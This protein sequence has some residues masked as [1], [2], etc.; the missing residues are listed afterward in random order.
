MGEPTDDD[1]STPGE[2]IIHEGMTHVVGRQIRRTNH[3]ASFGGVS[4]PGAHSSAV[5]DDEEAQFSLS[6]AA[7]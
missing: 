5:Y 3:H 7:G 4:F 2:Q 6:S 1:A